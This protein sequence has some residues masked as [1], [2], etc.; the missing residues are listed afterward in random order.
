ML[1]ERR[2]LEENRNSKSVIHW[3]KTHNGISIKKSARRCGAKQNV[4]NTML[5]HFGRSQLLKWSDNGVFC[6]FWLGNVL[7]ATTACT[8]FDIWTF[9]SG[10]N[11]VC[12]EHFHFP[13]LRS[14]NSLEKHS[15]SR[16]SYLFAHQNLLSSWLF[17]F[18]SSLIFLFSLPL[19]CSAFHL[20]I[21][22]EV[23]LLNFL[24]LVLFSLAPRSTEQKSKILL[25]SG[26]FNSLGISYR[27]LQS[28]LARSSW[29]YN[30]SFLF[31]AKYEL[32]I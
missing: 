12:F 30:F 24:G 1:E 5:G 3:D 28:H 27:P 6:T 16:L 17:L 31:F 20:S 4:Q 14:H 11:M 18:W 23:W 2:K 7:H 25:D 22:S 32:G 13:T 19:P 21:L 8:F 29:P 10:P 26:S 15:A 9:K